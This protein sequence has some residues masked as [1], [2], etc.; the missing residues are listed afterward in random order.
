[1]PDAG[2]SPGWYSGSA[3]YLIVERLIKERSK[4]L[5]VVSPYITPYYAKMLI[6]A[7]RGKEVRV[8]TSDSDISKDALRMM[9]K[10]TGVGPYAK[11]ASY[12]IALEAVLLLLKLYAAAFVVAPAFAVLVLLFSLRYASAGRR[13]LYVKVIGGR[14]V[15]E[16]LYISDSRAVV[17][18][19]NLTYGGMHRNVEHLELI[20]DSEKVKGLAGHFDSLWNE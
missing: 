3:S 1:M 18:S 13:R 5:R 17:G 4:T 16:K 11:T 7:S 8:I 14:L 6:G 2:D 10:R 15:H 20:N 12:F 9:G 19:A